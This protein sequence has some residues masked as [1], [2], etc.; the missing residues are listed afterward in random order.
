MTRQPSLNIFL[1]AALALGSAQLL[2]ATPS[3][4]GASGLINMPDAR[5]GS[6]GEF[7]SGYAWYRPYSAIW[8]NLAFTD[9]LE[10]SFRYTRIAYVDAGFSEEENRRYG[11]YKDKSAGAKIKLIPE[12]PWWPA[13]AVGK[14]DLTSV[15][16]NTQLYSSTY[17]TASKQ[18][19][20]LDL[21]LGRGRGRIDGYFGGVRWQP[22]E[23]LPLKLVVERDVNNYSNDIGAA[24]SGAAKRKK[25]LAY[26]LEYDWGG[27]STQLSYQHN[28][29]GLNV[30]TTASFNTRRFN[31]WIDEPKPFLDPVPRPTQAQ[32]ESNPEF[33]SALISALYKD[34]FRSIKLQYRDGFLQVSLSNRRISNMS[35]AAGRAARILL[36]H[37][38]VETR[39]IN[40]TYTLA[41]LPVAD[42]QF[43]NLDALRDYFWGIIPRSQLAESVRVSLAS[44]DSKIEDDE[45]EEALR[46]AKQ[47]DNES[48]VKTKGEATAIAVRNQDPY[49]SGYSIRPYTGFMFNDPSGALKYSLSLLGSARKRFEG[50]WVVEGGLRMDLLENLSDVSRASNSELPHVRS[51]VS[52]YAKAGRLQLSRL[53]VSKYAQ[54]GKGIYGRA[55]AGI[56]ERMFNG[57]GGQIAYFP[58]QSPWALD[59]SIDEVRQRDPQGWFK[60]RNY[61]TL[62]SLLSLHYRLTESL[63]LTSR[64]GR[65]L[66][67]DEG[68]RFEIGKRYNSGIEV[69]GWYTWTNG[70]DIT[71]PGSPTSPYHDKGIY[72][73]IP[74]ESLFTRD[75]QATAGFAIA[76]W[77]RDVGQMV[78]SPGDLYPMFRRSIIDSL[79]RKDGLTDFGEYD[80]DYPARRTRLSPL[81][82]PLSDLAIKDS[83][84]FAGELSSGNSMRNVATAVGVIGLASLADKPVSNWMKTN[85]QGRAWRSLGH[86]GDAVP[87]AGLVAGGVAAAFATDERGSMAGLASAE[88]GIAAIGLS[89]GIKYLTGRARPTDSDDARNFELGR[90]GKSYGSFPSRHAT[91]AWATLTP[92]A[93]AYD[94]DW[95]YGVAAL[96]SYSR[97]R[98]R[99]HWLSDSVAGSLIGYGLGSLTWSWRKKDGGMIPNSVSITPQG[100]SA[101][102][103]FK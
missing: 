79:F 24:Q 78:D 17:W 90:S 2:A 4:N 39:Q 101:Q 100:A 71:K 102:W 44:P 38:P 9:W 46:G 86:I 76:P 45:A 70:N 19:G 43:V 21:T 94:A 64:A 1:G 29:V 96:S 22:T 55:S 25:G 6:E 36:A 103:S 52:D 82:R 81:E 23:K 26:G 59:W 20:P 11:S 77:T 75:T 92:L 91:L 40:I 65:F 84:S 99:Q 88:A 15:A 18:L 58:E 87:Y 72:I 53:L 67:R 7:S 48:V 85:M 3:V 97:V 73:L 33:R 50:N 28:V 74:L 37:A 16:D 80:D 61:S 93:K 62:T 89:S 95:L 69:G 54:L 68:V 31:P 32:W 8:L 12:G 41:E 66:A 51:D 49:Q 5:I 83:K 57:V 47:A 63:T 13:F 10:P 56:Y 30:Y 60:M 98:S 27:F 14:T 35:R 34:D 42:Y